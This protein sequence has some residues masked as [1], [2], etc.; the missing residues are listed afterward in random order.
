[1]SH[2]SGSG[3]V[4]VPALLTLGCFSLLAGDNPTIET[5]LRY[6]LERGDFT[7][8]GAIVPAP[9]VSKRALRIAK[10]GELLL[11]TCRSNPEHWQED[12]LLFRFGHSHPFST[13][14]CRERTS[15]SLHV[16]FTAV[17]MDA[18]NRGFTSICTVRR[19]SWGI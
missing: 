11:Q 14:G 5:N 10:G 1:M 4:A 12:P 18:W 3:L 19:T 9:S 16:F 8:S 13:I 15:P 17:P 7:E 2:T 6:R